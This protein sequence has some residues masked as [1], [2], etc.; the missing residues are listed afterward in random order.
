M[1][2]SRDRLPRPVDHAVV[3]AQR[4]TAGTGVDQE[5]G[6]N[7][8]ETPIRR[9]TTAMT[10]A[11][12]G[13]TAFSTTRGGGLGR[14]GFGTPRSM[15]RRVMYGSPATDRA[16]TPTTSRGSGRG[17]PRGSVLPSWYPRVPL[18]DITWVVRVMIYILFSL[19]ILCHLVCLSVFF[20]GSILVEL[21]G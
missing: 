21:F 19:L 5:T 16:N 9:V 3:F 14:G 2:E 10:P 6:P 7:L 18:Q 4:R 12:R 11:T 13:Q 15:R 8:L 17:R 1:A 20:P